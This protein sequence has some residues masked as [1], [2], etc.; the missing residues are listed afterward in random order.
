MAAPIT[1]DD[2]SATRVEDTNRDG[3]GDR[4][5]PSYLFLG[6]AKT[7]MDFHPIFVFQMKG[8]GSGA[9]ISEAN[10]AVTQTGNFG[11]AKFPEVDLIALRVSD[12]H[13]VLLSDYHS[14]GTPIMKGFAGEKGAGVE[15]KTMDKA[16]SN[17]MTRFLQRHW[18]EGAYLFLTLRGGSGIQLPYDNTI[19]NGYGFGNVDEIWNEHSTDARISITTNP[20]HKPKK[21]ATTHVLLKAAGMTIH[22]KRQ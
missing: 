1:L 22:S 14:T 21:N 8:A 15:L 16:G 13:A 20:Q 17:A 11:P 4:I 10:F 3:R 2:V 12:H 18:K 9:A 6:N 7:P 5:I 19:A